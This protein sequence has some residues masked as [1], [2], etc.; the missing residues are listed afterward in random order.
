M[1]VAVSG[2]SGLIG[3]VLV[4][5]LSSLGHEPVRLVRTSA[6][7][8]GAIRWDPAA[9]T[10]EADRLEGVDALVNLAGA[11]LGD[12]RWTESYKEELRSSRIRGTD[13][14]AR[15]VAGLRQRPRI[16]VSGSAIGYYG[17]R[18]DEVL[19][20]DSAPGTGFLADLCRDWEAATAPASAA[21]VRVAYIRSG[22]VLSPRGGALKKMLPLFK[23]GLGGRFGKGDQWQSWISI[24]DEVN[25]IVH[26]LTHDVRGPVNLTAP[27]PVTNETFTKTLGS[28]LHRPTIV[29]VPSFGPRLLL[30][31]ELA[32]NLLFTGQRV[33][34]TALEQSGYEF[35]DRT[36][37]EA[38]T[39]LLA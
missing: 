14:L 16:M 15:T 33:V 26:L 29:P 8:A 6:A 32:D 22:V 5:T 38:L 17:A 7:E 30:G 23:L 31:S 1:K 2:S 35:R 4:A 10:I 34:P 20:E 12:H 37:D 18:G 24:D 39:R 3:T 19:D 21:G 13:L 25:A 9:G 27:T 36:L 11:G 28:A